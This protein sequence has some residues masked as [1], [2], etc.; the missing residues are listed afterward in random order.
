MILGLFDDN[1]RI[2]FSSVQLIGDLLFKI[3]GVTGKMS[4]EGGEDE[5]FGTEGSSKAIS[6]AL[7]EEHRNRILSGLYM[8]RSDI[9]LLVRQSAAHVS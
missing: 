4:A 5:T 7:G 1:W 3:S 6:E 2:R 9:G 8:A